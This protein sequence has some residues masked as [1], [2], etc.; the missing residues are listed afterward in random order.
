MN[1]EEA[2]FPLSPLDHLS[3]RLHVPK[4]LYFQTADQYPLYTIEIFRASL[5]KTLKAL[6]IFAGSLSLDHEAQQP[7]VC[8]QARNS[9]LK[10]S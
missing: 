8:F 7:G 2:K 9:K 5:E 1:M 10:C 4:F 6:P 3:L